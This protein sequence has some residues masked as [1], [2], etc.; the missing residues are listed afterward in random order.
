MSYGLSFG[1][2]FIWNDM[3]DIVL[4]RD[5]K[6]RP[7]SVEQAVWQLTNE[8]WTRLAHDV[9]HCEPEHLNIET[10]LQKIEE[11]NT[12]LNLDPPIAICIDRNGDFTILV[13]DRDDGR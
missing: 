6:K 2:D 5:P 12:C 11:T 1:P 10:V 13:W 9:F 8:T 7:T 3:H 4:G